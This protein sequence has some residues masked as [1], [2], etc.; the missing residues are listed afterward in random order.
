MDHEE[1]MRFALTITRKA[2]NSL[3]FNPPP[4]SKGF[5]NALSYHFTGNE[6]LEEKK[7]LAIAHAVAV[8]ERREVQKPFFFFTSELATLGF[9]G[10]QGSQNFQQPPEQ[11]SYSYS[12]NNHL[13]P[14]SDPPHRRSLQERNRPQISPTGQPKRPNSTSGLGNTQ[15]PP[16]SGVWKPEGSFAIKK[17]RKGKLT[18]AQRESAKRNRLTKSCDP[19]KCPDNALYGAVTA[20]TSRRTSGASPSMFRSPMTENKQSPSSISSGYFQPVSHPDSTGALDLNQAL[21]NP[22]PYQQ[23]NPIITHENYPTTPDHQYGQ[24]LMP[25]LTGIMT[26][27]LL[28]T[29]SSQ[30]PIVSTAGD[31][32]S[33]YI[34]FD[35]GMAANGTY[36]HSFDPY[37]PLYGS[38]MQPGGLASSYYENESGLESRPVS[39]HPAELAE[40]D[41]KFINDGTQTSTFN[42]SRSPRKANKS[43]LRARKFIETLKRYVIKFKKTFKGGK[44]A[45]TAI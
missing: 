27:D 18:D 24:P 28:V 25:D 8:E 34:N 17:G 38:Q 6:S 4:E 30:Q 31:D 3:H 33:S 39:I 29:G 1:G 12:P 37:N 2:D 20:E 21:N 9:I 16:G 35:E 43:E 45:G 26:P 44:T 42:T 14:P 13:T 32:W 5:A 19:Q 40:Y 23:P 10:T 7:K 15:G 41:L 36:A 11:E 22:Y